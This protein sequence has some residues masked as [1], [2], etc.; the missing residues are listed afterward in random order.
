MKKILFIFVLLFSLGLFFTPSFSENISD[1]IKTGRQLYIKGEIE[2]ALECFEKGYEISKKEGSDFEEGLCLLWIGIIKRKKGDLDGAVS[3]YLNSLSIFNKIK[4][5]E[6][7]GMVLEGIGDL[8]ES[9][10]EYAHSI[11]FF[12]RAL[13]DYENLNEPDLT[14]AVINR[15]GR[16]YEKVGDY[17]KSVELYEKYVELC[18]TGNNS[19]GVAGGLSNLGYI[20][21]LEGNYQKAIEYFENSIDICRNTGNIEGEAAVTLNIGRLYSLQGNYKNALF[22]YE[23]S[24]KLRKRIGDEIGCALPLNNIGVMYDKEGD[25]NKAIEYYEKSK[26]I[27]K[28][29]GSKDDLAR[30]SNNIGFANK[31]LNN[32]DVALSYFKEAL[33]IFKETKNQNGESVLLSNIGFLLLDI[34]NSKEAF[35]YLKQSFAISEKLMDLE[36][37]W[38]SGYGMGLC[39][40]EARNLREAFNYYKNS[41]NYIEKLHKMS[42]GSEEDKAISFSSKSHVYNSLVRVLLMLEKKGEIIPQKDKYFLDNEGNRFVGNNYPEIAYYFAEKGKARAI[43]EIL[44]GVRAVLD[45]DPALK[46]E[47]DKIISRI[48]ILQRKY[49]SLRFSPD[50]SGTVLSD[51]RNMISKEEDNL[52]KIKEKTLKTATFYSDFLYP[53][54]PTLTD[55]IENLPPD[56][57]VIEYVLSDKDICYFIIKKN[58]FNYGIIDIK[59]IKLDQII[60]KFLLSAKDLKGLNFNKNLSE[61][62]YDLVFSPFE[63]NICDV[64]NLIII[65]DGALNYMPFEILSK[66]G[67]FVG[68]TFNISYAP[69]INFLRLTK[70]DNSGDYGLL[71]LGYPEYDGALKDNSENACP[72]LSRGYF[73]SKGITWMPLP[74]TK[75]EFEAISSVFKGKKEI[76]L[77][78]NANEDIFKKRASDFSIIHFATHGMFDDNEPILYSS[79]ILAGANSD[80]SS[81]DNDGYL[82]AIEIFNLKLN[83]DLVVLSGCETGLGENLNGEGLMGLSTAFIC[84][85]AKSLIVSLWPVD[86]DA[87]AKLFGYFY[88]NLED[89]SPKDALWHAKLKL[90]QEYPQPFYWAAFI[91]V[92]E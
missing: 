28:K 3:Y 23:E 85:G 37:L 30:L 36:G 59:D 18:K 7:S 17:K 77:G 84:A 54:P 33:S 6:Y 62:I 38:I 78:I 1:I 16:N 5:Y 45:F 70:H 56:T 52:R 47:R 14:L 26:K 25:Y 46:G 86:D 43:S 29:L 51:L 12:E 55:A 15:L 87:C 31:S 49:E 67:S 39:M 71:G 89:M 22:Y 60:K 57:A 2:K 24:L 76:Y 92:G 65:P 53:S 82:R 72:N 8:Y 50:V 27:Y 81:G 74:G 79:I 80:V 91:L 66:S 42:F 35:E 75:R 61:K 73:N 69:S 68:E 13:K 34:K 41:V 4:R 90:M 20:F 48:S 44:Q 21:T 40:E 64:K 9:S 58:G 88:G 11:D 10:Y 83:A 19:N 32:F 63:K